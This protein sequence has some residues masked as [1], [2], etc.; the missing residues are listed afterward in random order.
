VDDCLPP[1][2]EI[3]FY[4]IVQ[5]TLNNVV[6]HSN[7]GTAHVSV[8]RGKSNVRLIVEDNGTGFDPRQRVNAGGLGLSGLSER[9]R[10]MGGNCEI[11]SRPGSGTVVRIEIPST[12]QPPSEQKEEP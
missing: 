5:E 1:E 8:T 9:V 11:V 6:K 2:F 12:S 10:I 4:R 7:A 3:N